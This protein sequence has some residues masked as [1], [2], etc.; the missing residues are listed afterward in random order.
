[1][2]LKSLDI[3]GFKSFADKT[4]LEFHHGV[5]G[6]VG[7]NGCGKSNVV[8]AIRWVLGETSAKALRG[9]EMSDVIFNGT[10]HRKASGMASVTLTLTEC[11][12]ALGSSFHEVA[13]TR[14]V[15]RD[16]KSEYRIN[17]ALC[18]LKDI[19]NLFL[20]TGIGRSSYSVMEQGKIDQLLSSKP[21][22]RRSVFEEAAG[23]SKFK[24]EKKEALRKLEHTSHNLLRVSDVMQEQEHRLQS[25]ERQVG[26]ARSYQFLRD[27]IRTLEIHLAHQ[28]L[29][30][31]QTQNRSLQEQL[32]QLQSQTEEQERIIPA[33]EQQCQS[34]RLESTTHANHISSKKNSITENES[35]ILRAESE[36]HLNRERR[37]DYQDRS[38]RY[39][40]EV[41]ESQVL[42]SELRQ[43]LTRLIHEHERSTSEVSTYRLALDAHRATL[44][45]GKQQ[46][47]TAEEAL[48]QT[49]RQFIEYE[50][51]LS[52]LI[53]KQEALAQQHIQLSDRAQDLHKEQEALNESQEH[54]RQTR[55]QQHTLLT[56]LSGE[57]PRLTQALELTKQEAETLDSVIQEQ[58]LELK[59]HDSQLQAKQQRQQF[60]LDLLTSGEHLSSGA[61][62]VLHTH[63]ALE[64]VRSHLH[65]TLS[66][67]LR[68]DAQFTIAIESALGQAL[69]AIIVPDLQTAQSILEH[70]SDLG[71]VALLPSDALEPTSPQLDLPPHCH[72]ASS[73]IE[74]P[75]AAVHALLSH[76]IIVPDLHSAVPLRAHHPDYTYATLTGELWSPTGLL[77]G[78]SQSAV[79]P[80]QI[81]AELDELNLQLPILEEQVSKLNDQI[82]GSHTERTS[83]RTRVEQ[84]QQEL[85]ERTIET[86]TLTNECQLL[87][88]ELARLEHQLSRHTQEKGQLND[89]QAEATSR[90]RDLQQ[91]EQSTL[92]LR[93]TLQSRIDE[94][95]QSY[96]QSQ[97]HV[98]HLHQTVTDAQTQLAVEQRTL[99]ALYHQQQPIKKRLTELDQLIRRR[100]S[101]CLKLEE[102]ILAS[103]S[104]DTELQSS[105][106]Q[107][108]AEILQLHE[109]L[110]QHQDQNTHTLSTLTTK[111]QELHKV[112]QALLKLSEQKGQEDLSRA[113]LDLK[114]ES[115]TTRIKERY[116]V[117]LP[118]F[119]PDL[120]SL[121][122]LLEAADHARLQ[123][124]DEIDWII[125]EDLLTSAQQQLNS[126]GAV[127]LDAIHE[128][129]ELQERFQFISQQYQDLTHAQTELL[130]M[131]D[132]INE[133]TTAL[134]TQTFQQ[135]RE[136]F[137]SMFQNLFGE[138]GLA[139]LILIDA[140]DP[141][142]SGIDIIA[143]PP[144]KKLQS[145]T[146]MS[147][148]E[149]SMTAVALL[150]SI[151]MVKPSPFCVLDELDAPLDDANIARFLKMLDSFTH[152]SQFI[153]VTHSKRTMA[154]AQVLYGIT[155][156]ERGVSTPIS[157]VLDQEND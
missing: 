111:E 7:P 57:L 39:Q 45:E 120:A 70:T 135:I 134:F 43:E 147:G 8:D 21:E 51:T 37:T 148:G 100:E 140:G 34:L 101:E 52:T 157:M 139:D 121:S 80:L 89:Q 26:K 2:R 86:K 85:Q 113:K 76:T 91:E 9:G 32:T 110:Q 143:K 105:L 124:W 136:N 84:H 49:R 90:L 146:L 54:T 55:E 40:Q 47:A 106:T 94:Q 15:Y 81:Q 42:V 88:K 4:T 75:H 46:L 82:A 118:H 27:Q 58:E 73:V 17:N 18:R 92:S 141:L 41:A 104:R 138:Q 19:H 10:D 62:A 96:Q 33:L 59:E 87:D 128:F 6:V 129:D 64:P 154:H 149:R 63:E 44:T 56:T 1:M 65:G 98:E 53:A 99:D 38:Q 123:N 78:G 61:Q 13:I 3:H 125:I 130:S 144:G 11:E 145:I 102:Q 133:E 35:A 60:L 137:S 131:I 114:I 68:T 142:E 126:L 31:L 74:S 150:F 48:N 66:E 29:S 112:R 95:S 107:R 119:S 77:T 152:Q 20:D 12:E 109:E 132:Q 36:L 30:E 97:Q 127:N 153:I 67:T 156:P 83:Y 14:R 69:S 117:D 25:L 108:R 155:M 24:K 116:T 151:Y 28:E 122:T 79:S 93:D 23:I 115:V 22:E 16:G 72:H 50:R 5:T 103:E 71:H